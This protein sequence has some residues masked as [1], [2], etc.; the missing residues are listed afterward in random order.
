MT[1]RALTQLLVFGFD[2]A[3]GQFE[4]RLGGALE[5]AESGGA[6]RINRALFVGRDASTGEFAVIDLHGG[7]GGLVAPLLSFRLDP[8]RRREATAR[9]LETN[10][11][12]VPTEILEELGAV[13]A[14]GEA[15]VAVLVEH[16]WAT[17]LAD[18]VARSGGRALADE[19]VTNCDAADFGRQVLAVSARRGRGPGAPAGQDC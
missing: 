2:S 3:E 5:R 17:A 4:G 19:L 9:A 1:T 18:A 11:A 12:G 15:I 14:P 7:A 13:L 6:L 16:V 8:A 10:E